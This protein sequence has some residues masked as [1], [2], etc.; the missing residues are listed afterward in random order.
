LKIVFDP[1]VRAQVPESALGPVLVVIE[2][3]V[4]EGHPRLALIEQQFPCSGPLFER[5]L[6][7]KPSAHNLIVER[8]MTAASLLFQETKI[9]LYRTIDRKH[10]PF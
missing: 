2:T 9:L 4:F 5:V 10:G 7:V 6:D 1:L 3:Q 8:T